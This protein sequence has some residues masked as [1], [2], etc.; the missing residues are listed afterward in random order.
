MMLGD[1]LF[2]QQYA[3]FGLE[4]CAYLITSSSDKLQ[5]DDIVRSDSPCAIKMEVPGFACKE[6]P[7]PTLIDFQ[8]V[9]PKPMSDEVYDAWLTEFPRVHT[10]ASAVRIRLKEKKSEWRWLFPHSD[11]PKAAVE[12]LKKTTLEDDWLSLLPLLKI[13]TP[14]ERSR[15]IASFRQQQKK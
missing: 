13:A 1:F 4:E 12:H 2:L 15:T 10:C 14:L 3:D 5:L 11:G 9:S 8:S 7:L 6:T